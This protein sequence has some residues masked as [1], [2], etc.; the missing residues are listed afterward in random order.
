M[1]FRTLIELK[2]PECIEIAKENNSSDNGQTSND[3]PGRPYLSVQEAIKSKDFEAIQPFIRANGFNPN[4]QTMPQ[5]K[6]S[7]YIFI[8]SLCQVVQIGPLVPQLV[9]YLWL[10]HSYTVILGLNGLK[11]WK[12]VIQKGHFSIQKRP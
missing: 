1:L 3:F 7:I 9:N 5:N 4:Q 6:R 10:L 11:K 8:F 12:L 2:E